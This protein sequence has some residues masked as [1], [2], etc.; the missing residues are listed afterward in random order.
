VVAAQ[1]SPRT[2]ARTPQATAR[3]K[4][5]AVA[6]TMVLIGLF[7]WVESAGWVPARNLSQDPTVLPRSI[8][9]VLWL[10]AAG[11]LARIGAA[12][13]RERAAAT[14]ASSIG[15]EAEDCMTAGA[16]GADDESN[17][18]GALAGLLAVTVYAWLAFRLGWATTTWV[19]LTG[20]V[21]FLGPSR[22][23]PR[24]VAL[25]A[26]IAAAATALIWFGFVDALRV[27]IPSTLLP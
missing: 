21:A 17:L 15:T 11:M 13:R 22:W 8:A 5:L 7:V 24:R 18:V 16:A 4:D 1:R 2:R 9:V 3:F 27:R 20:S 6:S 10:V 26:L 23:S 19:F 12:S 25:V 14:T